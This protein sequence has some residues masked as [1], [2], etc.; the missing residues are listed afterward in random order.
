[1]DKKYIEGHAKSIREL[2]GCI[3]VGL[4]NEE[5]P[6][7]ILDLVSYM[8]PHISKITRELEKVIT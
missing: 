7:Y 2:V 3:Q 1:M 6:E 4:K 5:K 8:K